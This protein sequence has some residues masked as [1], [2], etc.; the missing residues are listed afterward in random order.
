MKFGRLIISTLKCLGD[1]QISFI[2]WDS[3]TCICFTYLLIYLSLTVFG[4]HCCSHTFSRCC[5][6]RLLSSFRAQASLCGDFSCY[7]TWALG[8]VGFTNCGRQVQLPLRMLES[9]RTRDQTHVPAFADKLLNAEPPG[10]STN[11]HI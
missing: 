5:E 9:S 8:L 7:R 4:L 10:K 11:I 1:R 3:G 2:S 6:W